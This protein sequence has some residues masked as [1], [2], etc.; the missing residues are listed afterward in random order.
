[1]FSQAF[2]TRPKCNFAT[3]GGE[4]LRLQLHIMDTILLWFLRLE[5]G[6]G[7]RNRL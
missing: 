5:I 1:M 3:H 6:I 4:F 2:P 7:D